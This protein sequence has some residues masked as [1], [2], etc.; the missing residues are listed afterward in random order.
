MLD[1]PDVH[2]IRCAELE[3]DRFSFDRPPEFVHAFQVLGSGESKQV[4][5]LGVHVVEGSRP[6]FAQPRF[7]RWSDCGA[8]LLS[9]DD[10]VQHLGHLG[11]LI[12]V[13]DQAHTRQR[14]LVTL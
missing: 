8:S 9:P 11:L 2:A 14:Q 13:G 3:I 12:G 6:C 10:R 1:D 5:I 7:L 4:L